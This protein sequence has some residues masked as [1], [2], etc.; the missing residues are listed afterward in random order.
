MTATVHHT[1]AGPRLMRVGL[2][3]FRGVGQQIAIR[4]LRG[5]IPEITL[6]AS[7]LFLSGGGLVDGWTAP[8]LRHEHA[9]GL[10]DWKQMD[11]VA[12]LKTG[13]TAQTTS[14]GPMNDVVVDSM[15]YMSDADLK[16]IGKYLI[17]LKPRNSNAPA[18]IYDN[19]IA[20][21]FYAGRVVSRGAQLYLDRCAACHRANGTGYGSAFPSLAGN[22]VLQTEDGTSAINIIL[23]GGS[24]PATAQAPSRLTMAPY[25]SCSMTSKLQISPPSYRLAGAIAAPPCRRRT[26]LRSGKSPSRSCLQISP[27]CKQT[28]AT[29]LLRT[30]SGQLNEQIRHLPGQ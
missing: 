20:A 8:S 11:I 1:L 17:T 9:G 4:L 29:L 23:S 13:R 6:V 15:Q 7:N 30:E 5:D 26:S 3:G 16:A 22:P 18:F 10:A 21:S 28:L 19:T 2:V 24:Q 12:F 14:F 25:A 27:R